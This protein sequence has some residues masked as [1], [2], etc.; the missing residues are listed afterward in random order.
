MLSTYSE[1]KK[2]RQLNQQNKNEAKSTKIYENESLSPYFCK[3]IGK[4]NSLLKKNQLKSFYTTNGK[5]N[6]KHDS[7][8]FGS[9]MTSRVKSK[10]NPPR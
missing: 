9:E 5:L 10:H 3:L 4:C 2:K 8:I 6:I 7:E 1:T